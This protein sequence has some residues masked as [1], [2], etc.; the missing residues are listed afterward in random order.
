MR[1][2][3]G[4]LMLSLAACASPLGQGDYGK[5]G[6]DART[7]ALVAARAGA[8]ALTRAQ[9]AAM[10]PAGTPIGT[11]HY[12]ACFAYQ[13]NWKVR[14]PYR[15]ECHLQLTRA[16]AVA[17]VSESIR[18]TARLFAAAGCP[19]P[20]AFEDSFGYYLEANGASSNA[21]Y[22]RDTDLPQ[23]LFDCGDDRRVQA[24]FIN[25]GALMASQAL[26]NIDAMVGARRIALVEQQGYDAGE[27]TAL[28]A[29][30]APLVVLVAIDS[31]YHAERW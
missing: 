25:P 29:T 19:N 10:T 31:R 22:R 23:V 14:D 8:E 5:D 2:I 9:L 28:R 11:S 20:A 17:N 7:P 13:R 27:I 1:I 3:L 6:F 21:R 18:E 26:T 15:I 24:Q 16:V 4:L 30:S 12:D